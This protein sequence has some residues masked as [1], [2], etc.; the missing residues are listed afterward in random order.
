MSQLRNMLKE[1]QKEKMLRLLL[2]ADFD[3]ATEEHKDFLASHVESQINIDVDKIL[4]EYILTYQASTPVAKKD[5]KLLYIHVIGSL[6][7]STG[8]AYGVNREEWVFVV[9]L[10]IL[11]I[12]IQLLPLIYK[13]D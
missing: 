13:K 9:F 6:V 4:N 11:M 10:G 12:L 3:S 7:L 5:S 1:I 2:G 8:I